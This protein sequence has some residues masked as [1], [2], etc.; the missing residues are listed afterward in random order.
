[1]ISRHWPSVRSAQCFFTTRQAARCPVPPPLSVYR[2]PFG[3]PAS[4]SVSAVLSVS[5][6][7]PSQTFG[8]FQGSTVCTSSPLGYSSLPLSSGPRPTGTIRRRVPGAPGDLGFVEPDICGAFLG[9]DAELL[10]LF[11]THGSE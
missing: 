9:I 2:W 6:A 7:R 5:D 11:L 10:G 3:I 4:I 8:G 1:M